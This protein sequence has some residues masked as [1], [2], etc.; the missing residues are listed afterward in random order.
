ME[1]T[2]KEYKL[3][4][5]IAESLQ[6]M[7]SLGMHIKFVQTYAES[8]LRK[9]LSKVLS[10]PEHKIRKT[11]GALYTSLVKQQGHDYHLRD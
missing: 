6:D 8:H 7:D 11:R 9:I 3:A 10:I 1:Y 5:E 4:R 2:P